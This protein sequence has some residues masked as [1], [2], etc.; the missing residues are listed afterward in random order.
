MPFDPNSPVM[1]CAERRRQ[2]Q[3]VLEHLNE[4]GLRASHPVIRPAG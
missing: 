2:A 4:L 3:V 1:A